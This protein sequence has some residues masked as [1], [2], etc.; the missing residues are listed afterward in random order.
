M[1]GISGKKNSVSLCAF[2]VF[3]VVKKSKKLALNSFQGNTVF[4][5]EMIQTGFAE[6]GNFAGPGNIL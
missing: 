6:S 1:A 4:F 3:S 5:Q 2:S